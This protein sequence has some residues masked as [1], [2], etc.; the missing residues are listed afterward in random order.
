MGRHRRMGLGA[1]PFVSIASATVLII[2]IVG[3][4]RGAL[5]ARNSILALATVEV[6]PVRVAALI[7]EFLDS[8]SC[9]TEGV[10]R[11]PHGVGEAALKTTR[12]HCLPL[13]K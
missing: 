13:Q 10:R 6:F 9:L 8:M 3:V 4:A 12:A 1:A 11:G 5:V 7:A 2:V